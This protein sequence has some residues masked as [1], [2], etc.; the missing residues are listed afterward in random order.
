MHHGEPTIALEWLR[1]EHS[2]LRA[3]YSLRPPTLRELNMTSSRKRPQRSRR[4]PA[5]ASTRGE[6]L[7]RQR[8][9]LFAVLCLLGVAVS[10]QL[11]RIHVLVY[12]DPNYQS[13]CA[14]SEGINCETVAAS[15]YAVFAG[16]PVSVW[17]ILGYVSMGVLALW[18]MGRKRPHPTWPWGILWV[19]TLSSATVSALL[20]YISAT[21]I[22]SLCLFCMA[23]YAINAALL[24]LA[25]SYTRQSG[26]RAWS[27]LVADVTAWR[28]RPLTPTLLTLVGLGAVALLQVGVPRYWHTPGWDDLPRLTQGVD[29]RGH[30]WIGAATPQLTIVE[31]SDYECPHCRAAH[32]QIR[33]LAARYPQQI[34]LIHRHLPLDQDCHPELKRPF[35]QYACRF[36][37]AAEC[38]GSQGYFWQMNDALFAIQESRKARDVDVRALAIGIGLDRS[39]FERCVEERVTAGRLEEDLREAIDRKL[40]GTPSYL[41]NGRIFLGRIPPE[42]LEH[43]LGVPAPAPSHAGES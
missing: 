36:A 31:F 16:L 40:S 28:A 22:D 1:Q 39:E 15:P 43:L 41:V 34:R 12:T 14:V 21:R 42:E 32:K 8:P 7:A 38:A 33:Q 18:S 11:T 30:H 6:A 5:A 35:H 25:G 27:L 17:G 37:L 13:V 29:E 10:I 9:L 19:L 4:N 24:V 23:S 3:G 26:R 20:A 2:L